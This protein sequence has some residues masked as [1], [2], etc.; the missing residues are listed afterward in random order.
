MRCR[1]CKSERIIA[2][3]C[4]FYWER[5]FP[6]ISMLKLIQT[7]Q[8]HFC[9]YWSNF[10]WYL[11]DPFIF[12]HGHG[13]IGQIISFSKWKENSSKFKVTWSKCEHFQLMCFEE[14][15]VSVSAATISVK[16]QMIEIRLKSE[17]KNK[18]RSRNWIV[19][20]VVRL[21]VRRK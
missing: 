2:F 17:Y 13:D 9:R 3:E 14:I 12:T 8:N 15:F 21:S 4:K 5:I 6:S 16:N 1:S 20:V 10:P 18:N 7:I 19:W 11:F